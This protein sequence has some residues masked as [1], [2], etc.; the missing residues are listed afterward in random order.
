MPGDRKVGQLDHP[1]R[2]GSKRL[3]V[4]TN[5]VGPYFM[6]DGARESVHGSQLWTTLSNVKMR[7][8]VPVHALGG[9]LALD[10]TDAHEDADLQAAIAASLAAQEEDASAPM[11]EDEPAPAAPPVEAAGQDA[12]AGGGNGNGARECSICLT[13]P[14]DTLMRPCNHLI[15]CS[16]CA[17]RLARAP[18]PVC[19]RPVHSV[20]RV[21]F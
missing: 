14:V 6:L 3:A 1:E 20:E 19:R 10:A 18:C 16:A 9:G 5:S 8:T 12:D 17:R 11:D 21:F 4:Y 15:A 13:E 7:G 2:Y